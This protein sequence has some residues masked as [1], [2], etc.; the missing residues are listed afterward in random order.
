LVIHSS[1]LSRDHCAVLVARETDGSGVLAATDLSDPS[2]PVLTVARE[3]A[4]LCHE[5][6]TG[7][8]S[9]DFVGLTSLSPP[10]AA[11]SYVF[12]QAE[13]D[14]AFCS[15]TRH[16]RDAMEQVHARGLAIVE[17]GSPAPAILRLAARMRSRLVVVGAQGKGFLSNLLLGSVSGAVAK[18]APCSVLVMRPSATGGE[19][20]A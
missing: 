14:A 15:A 2:L 12:A 5:P 19:Q 3:E 4:E 10:T 1:I 20:A 16:L 18:Q 11:G 8:F 13:V 6:L 7:V 9:L 17:R